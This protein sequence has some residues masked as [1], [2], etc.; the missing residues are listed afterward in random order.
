MKKLKKNQAV[1][2]TERQR[3][4][5]MHKMIYST[6]FNLKNNNMTICTIGTQL[7]NSAVKLVAARSRSHGV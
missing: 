3:L 6:V 7:C 5:G 1:T 2:L 4:S